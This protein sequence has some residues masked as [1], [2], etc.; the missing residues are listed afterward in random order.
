MSLENTLISTNNNIFIELIKDNSEDGSI[1][2][3][4]D[5]GNICIKDHVSNYY[6]QDK[7]MQL[8]KDTDS[9]STTDNKSLD[10]LKD[11]SK[12]KSKKMKNKN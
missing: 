8:Y 11:K 10:K 1:D 9:D 2:E 4:N 3:N 12:N 7:D 6:E 5:T